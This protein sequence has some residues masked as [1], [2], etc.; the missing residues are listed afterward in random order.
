MF[1][2]KKAKFYIEEIVI[3][4]EHLHSIDIIYRDLK[5]ENVLLDVKGH[6]KLVDFGLSKRLLWNEKT[7]TLCGTPEYLAPEVIDH[8]YCFLVMEKK[9]TTGHLVSYFMKWYAVGRLLE[10]VMG[11]MK[12]ENF[13]KG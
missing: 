3:A 4:I 8:V 9:S 13:T 2:E 7:S 10:L 12:H 6:I 11:Q 1:S 5:L